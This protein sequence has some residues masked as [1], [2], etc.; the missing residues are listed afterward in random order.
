MYFDRRA[1][2]DLIS[3]FEDGNP[4]RFLLDAVRG[5]PDLDLQFRHDPKSPS[6]SRATVYCGGTRLLEVMY[7][8]PGWFCLDSNAECRAAAAYS[9]DWDR[10]RPCEEYRSERT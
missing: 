4:F 3:S 1:H 2:A 8:Q 9:T 5:H 10:R 6:R 7:S